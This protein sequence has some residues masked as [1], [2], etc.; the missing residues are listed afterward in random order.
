MSTF[1]L[2]LPLPGLGVASRAPWPVWRDSTRKEVRFQP[3]PKRQA[4]KLYHHARRL[5]RQTRAHNRQDGAIGRNGLL[6]LHALLFDFMHYA[7]GRLDPSIKAIARAANISESSVKR[8]LVKLKAAGVVTWLRRCAEDWIDGRFVLR[9]Q[10][11]AYG[12]LPAS[13]WRGYEP[14]AAPPA[15][16]AGTWG[17]LPSPARSAHQRLPGGQRRGDGDGARQRPSRWAR[18][19]AGPARA[20]RHGR[21]SLVLSEVQAERETKLQFIFPRTTPA[22]THERTPPC[23][24]STS[25]AYTRA[26]SGARRA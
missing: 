1:C 15:P 7:S 8:G 18:G 2:S 17:D 26:L 3:L 19:G 5:E 4:V 12:V 14:P 10:T 13:Q 25:C 24:A 20:R 22:H 9:Q 16:F 21:E 23:R 6:A 11:N